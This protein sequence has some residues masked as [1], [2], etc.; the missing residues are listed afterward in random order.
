[1]SQNFGFKRGETNFSIL[2]WEKRGRTKF[3]SKILGGEPKPYTLWN[4]HHHQ[5]WS[6]TVGAIFKCFRLFVENQVIKISII[7]NLVNHSVHI[8]ITISIDP[9]L[10]CP[11]P[12]SP[13]QQ[14][15]KG[16]G[17]T[18]P[19]IPSY[20]SSLWKLTSIVIDPL[21][22]AHWKGLMKK[23]IIEFYIYLKSL[24]QITI[25][26]TCTQNWKK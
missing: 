26:G 24:G 6:C 3:F 7:V 15:T 14:L 18:C 22:V 21:L 8:A 17:Q 16:I 12:H 13:F 11:I 10:Q 4:H 19:L 25:L 20:G 2:G 23:L 9:I 5:P 1:M